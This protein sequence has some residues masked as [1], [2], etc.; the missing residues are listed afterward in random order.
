MFHSIQNKS[1]LQAEEKRQQK[2]I[3]K[4]EARAAAR[5]EER[6][7]ERRSGKCALEAPRGKEAQKAAEKVDMMVY[8][9]ETVVSPWVTVVL[10]Y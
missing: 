10:G 8:L 1:I 5:K 3:A 2:K 7:G 4:A 6:R 9:N